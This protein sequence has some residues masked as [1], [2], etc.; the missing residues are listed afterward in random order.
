M[1]AKGNLSQREQAALQ[2][3]SEEA[4]AAFWEQTLGAKASF[5]ADHSHGIGKASRKTNEFMASAFD[6]LQGFSPMVDM[7][8]DVASP[9]GGLAI[10]TISFLFAV[11]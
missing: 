8:K 7:I 11:G 1:S 2:L 5:D 4:V 3:S 6:L 10:G 9:Y